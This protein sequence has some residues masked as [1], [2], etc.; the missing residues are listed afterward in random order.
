MSCWLGGRVRV[1][2]VGIFPGVQLVEWVW[3]GGAFWSIEGGGGGAPG[4]GEEGV[5]C[6]GVELLFFRS[7]FLRAIT[8]MDGG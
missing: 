4:K 8:G 1:D 6:G 7:L 3:R 2:G 5:W